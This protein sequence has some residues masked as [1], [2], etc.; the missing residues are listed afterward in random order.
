MS[1]T[2]YSYIRAS[3]GLSWLQPALL[4]EES[5]LQTYAGL[6]GQIEST[7][8]TLNALG[9]GRGD[10]V[11]LALPNG[12][13]AAVCSISV[14]CAA[15]SAPLNPASTPAEFRNYLTRINPK[16]VI[17]DDRKES[18][19]ASI[20]KGL[21]IAVIRLVSEPDK[22]AGTFR[23]EGTPQTASHTGFAEPDDVALLVL[24]SGS[25]SRPKLAPLT[26]RNVT[27]GAMNNV[28]QLGLTDKDRCLCVAALFYTQGILVS[29]LSSLFAGGSVACTPG[30]DPVRFFEWLDE[31]QP[32][33]Y[34][35][36]TALQQSIVARAAQYPEIVARAN[37]RV[38]RSSSAHAGSDL[39]EKV[40]KLFRAPMLDSYGLTET[41]STI[42][43]EP[44][45]PARRKHGSVG[46]AFGCE[47]GIADEL[48][49]L[50]PVGA[51]GE[52]LVRGP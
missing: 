38:I 35:A 9:I 12:P 45:P 47:I 2:I 20:A 26:H 8:A 14:A 13:D 27:S 7:V 29:V 25:T 36:P 28:V 15:T 50:L 44:L 4:G 19:A 3:A 22:P 6:I 18:H 21:G 32:T 52:V 41:S 24:T 31:F 11:A 43:G 46:I 42:V 39:I 10:R 51:T 23:L 33:W 30:Y 17:V 34:A 48:G 37:L 1:Q 49:R 40:E 16:A 5:R